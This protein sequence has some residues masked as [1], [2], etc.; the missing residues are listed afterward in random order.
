MDRKQYKL[1]GLSSGG[2]HYRELLYAIQEI[3]PSDVLLITSRKGGGSGLYSHISLKDPHRNIRNF[4]KTIFESL[5]LVLKLKAKYVVTTG[6]GLTVPF[7][8]FISLRPSTKLIVIESAARV[9]SLS[10]TT[11]LLYPFCSLL[12]IQNETLATKVNFLSK[13]K[14]VPLWRSL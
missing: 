8:I 9:N 7:C 13:V 4:L 6:A 3:D 5:N 12:I 1:I 10:L 14:L 11:K 2:G